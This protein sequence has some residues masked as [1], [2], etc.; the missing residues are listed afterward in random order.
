[1]LCVLLYVIPIIY[2]RILI[3]H[4]I[5]LCK[6]SKKCPK[7]ESVKVA[8]IA[9]GYPAPSSDWEKSVKSGE[10]VMGGCCITPGQ[11]DW[12]CQSCDY[13]W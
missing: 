2:K 4:Q 1:M 11:P 13:E 9:Y 12:Q 7:C 5:P 10:I 6:M 3:T 8:K